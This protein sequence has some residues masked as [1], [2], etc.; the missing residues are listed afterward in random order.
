MFAALI[1]LSATA[2]QAATAGNE[3]LL[4]V[5]DS[6]FSGF[7]A[8]SHI[9][10]N[11]GSLA[12]QAESISH[13][14]AY[15]SVNPILLTHVIKAQ[16]PQ[17]MQN[18]GSI[19]SLARSLGSL[20]T[21][22][23]E[24][25]RGEVVSPQA[26]QPELRGLFSFSDETASKV[27]D[28]TRQETA[29]AGLSTPLAIISDIPPAFDLPFDRP[30]AW[31]FNGAHTWTG[32]DDGSPMSSLDFVRSWSI[33]WGDDTSDDWVA[34][35]HDGEVTVHSSCF[36]DVL[37][38]SGWATRYYH[39]DNLQVASG[40]R[41]LAGDRLGNYASD[42]DQALCSGGHST[43]PHLHFALRRDGQYYSLQD[44]ALSGYIV[45]PGDSSYDAARDRMWLLKRGEKFYAFDEAIA[46]QEGD[47]TIDYRYNGMWFSADHNGH[48]LNVE[49]TEFPGEEES[50]KSV[51]FV[52]YT[53]DDDGLANFYAGNRDYD[54]WRSDESMMVDMLQTSGG[55]FSNLFPVDF[56]D[57]ESVQSAG[58][59]ELRFFDC[60]NAQLYLSLNERSSGQAVE[61]SISL[62][63]LIGVPD[64]VCAAASLPLP[65][66]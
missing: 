41:I 55:D 64:H 54:R 44:I 27:I 34:T 47:N 5:M 51:F 42:E 36:V 35:A 58:E 37:H 46:Q 22:Q 20:S 11:H 28:L 2:L 6:R 13:W 61:H 66:G 31:Q 21:L 62:T 60:R 17:V 19:R 50:R 39:L 49:I 4:L 63:K 3:G 65:E 15:Y 59:A 45:H 53:Y 16:P 8:I 1:S 9:Q 32:D 29:A 30:Q 38:D 24:L 7:D 23:S 14:A 40:Q 57:P 26:L 52:M 18:T 48:G 33:D 10:R 12:A 25:R 56:N 43:G